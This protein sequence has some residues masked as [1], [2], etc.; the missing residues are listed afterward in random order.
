[1]HAGGDVIVVGGGII[2][3]AIAREL[4]ARGARVRI[5]EAR[6]VAAGATQASAGILAPYIEGH[7]RGP[8][9]D[10]TLRSLALYEEFISR[11][12]EGSAVDVEYRRCGSLEIAADDAAAAVLQRSSATAGAELR[13]L[14]A[15]ETRRLEPAL[16][17]SIRGAVLAPTHGYVAVASLTE[18]L[19]WASLRHGA[20]LETGRHVRSIERRADHLEVTADDGARWT[21]PHV[22]I[23]SGSWS[24]QLAPHDPAARAV[25]PI[26]GQ[27]LRLAWTG[28]PLSHVI[29]GRD[30]YVVPW[31]DGTV[32]VGATVEDVGFD[33]RPTAAGVRD[34]LEAVCELLPEAWGATFLNARA[35]LRPA[36]PDA[37][38]IIGASS[39]VEGVVYATGHYRNGVLLA[40]LTAVIVADLILEGRHDP[41]LAVTAPDRITG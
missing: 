9:F 27:L 18:A 17:D 30:C 32:L 11:V 15:A 5:I 4:A 3:C 16:P 8:L 13:W 38:P 36:T 10:L 19:V 41:A 6:T 20:E 23:A 34:L 14:D 1:M 39:S 24:G 33:E 35:G 25:R 37:L 22:V 29:W 31:R 26:R 21:A 12:T 2:G 28:H 40:P 7:E